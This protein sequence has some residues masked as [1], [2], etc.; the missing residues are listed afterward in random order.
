MRPPNGET[1]LYSSIGNP[2][3]DRTKETRSAVNLTKSER[4]SPRERS[5]RG[6]NGGRVFTRP[7]LNFPT[8]RSGPIIIDMNQPVDRGGN[9]SYMAVGRVSPQRRHRSAR[10]GRR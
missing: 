5:A 2:S 3:A 1:I 7:T 9:A 10:E 4:I 8:C 6:T